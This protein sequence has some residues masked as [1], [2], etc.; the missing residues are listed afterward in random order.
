MTEKKKNY[1]T[2]AIAGTL[3]LGGTLS[4]YNDSKTYNKDVVIKEVIV[5]KNSEDYFTK[6]W[7][8]EYV[9]YD[10]EAR[11]LDWDNFKRVYAGKTVPE[12]PK[13]KTLYHYNEYTLISVPTN[14]KGI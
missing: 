5:E 6:E 3:I 2:L 12:N 13:D 8:S 1:L 11:K 7:F 9:T 14:Q 4:L 10:Y